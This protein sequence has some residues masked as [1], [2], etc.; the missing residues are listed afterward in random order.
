M[1]EL[2]LRHSGI[3]LAESISFEDDI[4]VRDGIVTLISNS[5]SPDILEASIKSRA[6]FVKLMYQSILS[7]YAQKCML[8]Q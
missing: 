4:V 8:D 6:Q 3:K 2:Q 1:K 5:N 7:F